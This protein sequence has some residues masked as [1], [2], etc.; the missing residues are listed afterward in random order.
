MDG[1]GTF[2]AKASIKRKGAGVSKVNYAK[3]A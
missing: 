3:Y 2:N 1:F